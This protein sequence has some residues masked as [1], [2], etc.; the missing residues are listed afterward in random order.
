MNSKR[1]KN[2]NIPE[3]VSCRGHSSLSHLYT[4]Q[5]Q[6]QARVGPTLRARVRARILVGWPGPH[7]VKGQAGP[8]WPDPALYPIR[9]RVQVFQYKKY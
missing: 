4:V 1:K 3:S 6:G 5:G 9:E 7:R 8:T 2:L